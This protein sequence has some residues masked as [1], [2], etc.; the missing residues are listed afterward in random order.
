[1]TNFTQEYRILN[2][3]SNSLRNFTQHDQ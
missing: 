1:M 3:F 2:S